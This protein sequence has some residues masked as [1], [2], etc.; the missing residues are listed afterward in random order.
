M[1]GSRDTEPGGLC[2][3]AGG[4]CGSCLTL[5]TSAVSL[6]RAGV[7]ERVQTQL[8][9]SGLRL[10]SGISVRL[11]GLA[12]ADQML[13]EV[14]PHREITQ[15]ADLPWKHGWTRDFGHRCGFPIGRGLVW[16]REAGWGRN[17]D[18]AAS[19][20]LWVHVAPPR[21]HACACP[22]AAHSSLVCPA[23]VHASVIQF[24]RLFKAIGAECAPLSMGPRFSLAPLC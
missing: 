2:T 23:P 1:E 14:D 19:P 20:R 16:R 7:L 18:P 11:A 17:P 21:A 13:V 4:L 8:F 24:L 9:R 5:R 10:L 22:S 15:D 12:L 6:L 3:P